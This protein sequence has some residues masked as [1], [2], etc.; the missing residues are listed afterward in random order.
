MLLIC[1]H[2]VLGFSGKEQEPEDYI[3][4]GRSVKCHL[5]K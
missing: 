2:V 4:D 3:V 1:L 5:Y